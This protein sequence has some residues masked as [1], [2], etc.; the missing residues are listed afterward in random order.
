MEQTG[1]DLPA[2]PELTCHAA[3]QHARIR[4]EEAHAANAHQKME[5]MDET[6][7]VPVLL[8]LS[9]SQFGFLAHMT[10]DVFG[11]P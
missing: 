4:N 11:G 1:T 2:W 10:S 3:T 6:L 7:W 9:H 8:F 5:H